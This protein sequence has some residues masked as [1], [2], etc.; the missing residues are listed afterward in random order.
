LIP[1][2]GPVELV[3]GWRFII[4]FVP[5]AA[6]RGDLFNPLGIVEGIWIGK[7]TADELVEA[8]SGYLSTLRRPEEAN[9]LRRHWKTVR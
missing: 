3:T 4:Q 8:A 1:K 6:W 9:G 5:G 7:P 2:A